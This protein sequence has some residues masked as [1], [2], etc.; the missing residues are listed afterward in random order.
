MRRTVTACVCIAWMAA[1]CVE[2]SRS[3]QA[4]APQATPAP[5]PANRPRRP[6]PRA[7]SSRSTASRVTTSD[8]RPRTCCST[9][10]TP[11]RCRNSA[12]TWEKV[13]VQLRSRA[14]PPASMP[15]PDNATYDTVATWLETELDR[16][17]AAR[18]NPGRPADLHR[19][20]RTEYANAVRDLLGIEIDAASMLPPDAQAHGFDTNADALGD[21]AGA[22]GSLSDRGGE[23]RA[24]RRRR[25]DAPPRRRA[26]HRRQ[27]QLERTDVAVADRAPGRDRSRWARAAGSRR[28]TTSRS[29]ANTSSRSGCCRTYADVIRGLNVPSD[30][31]D[32]R[33]W[34]ARRAVHDRRRHP[35]APPSHRTR[36]T[37]NAAGA[38]AAEGRP[39]PGARDHR[40]V[41]GRQGRGARTGAHSDLEPRRR[42]AQRPT[43][44][45]VAADRRAVQ[46]PRAEGLAEPPAH[47]RVPARRAASDETACATKIL[48]TLAR[49]A[50]RRPA[51]TDDVQTLLGFY[52][53]GAC[54][55]R[56][57]HRHPRGARA[58]ARQP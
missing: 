52:Q 6:L 26:L 56:L 51:T 2:S 41:R 44:D 47:L 50:Y 43:L 3:V 38:R 11:T 18:P 8:S 35:R 39:P 58:A 23:D 37:T 16:A 17:A 20:N 5:A 24:R 49:R 7:R 21:R 12:D 22:A 1:V 54:R 27:G 45:L 15:R 57:R 4:S 9:R 25:P 42:R 33:R 53:R 34:R 36:P 32:S 30:D 29:M 46:R 10:L 14:M 31:R 48:S 55:R 13:V 28:A 40:Q 19:L